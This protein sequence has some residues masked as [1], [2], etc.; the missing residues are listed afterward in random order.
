ML[1]DHY[2]Q[3][4]YNKPCFGEVYNLAVAKYNELLDE[5]SCKVWKLTFCQ[6]YDFIYLQRETYFSQLE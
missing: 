5:N 1:T 2:L 6:L 4:C 3:L